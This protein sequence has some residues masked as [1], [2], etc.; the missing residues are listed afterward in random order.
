MTIL[1]T[2]DV[3][4]EISV[5]VS[6]APKVLVGITDPSA[7]TTLVSVPPPP[8]FRVLTADE[9]TLLA[10][11]G[12]AGPPGPQG[13]PGPP[14]PPGPEGPEG[15]EGD[16]GATGATGPP[17]STGAAG[18]QGP[19]GPQGIPG[20]TGPTGATGPKGD[21]GDKGDIGADSTVPG[22]PGATGPAGS[23]GP[24]GPAGADSTVPGPTGPTG[25]QGVK[26]D[27]GDQGPTGATGTAGAPGATGPAGAT[28]ATGATGPGV[29]P[30][31]TLDQV[32]AKASAVDYAT[33]WVTPAVGVGTDNVIGSLDV[34]F[35]ADASANTTL[36]AMAA[37][38]DYLATSV[39][40]VT[41]VD[42]TAVG[43]VRFVVKRMATA[44]AA[45]AV[46]NL[47][48]SLTD[49]ASVFSAAAWTAIPAQVSLVTPNITLDTGWINLPV[50]MKVNNVY[51]A[52]T[53]AGGDGSAAPVVGSIRAFFKG[54]GPLGPEGPQGPA[55]A[56]GVPG[57]D[58]RIKVRR[59]SAFS[60]TST[61]TDVI[62]NTEIYDTNNAYN[63]ATGVFTAPQA[64]TYKITTQILGVASAVGVWF[65]THCLLNGSTIANGSCPPAT[66][67]NQV[68]T[69]QITTTVA[70]AAN[71]T[72]KIA[73]QSMGTGF[74]DQGQANSDQTFLTIELITTGAQGPVGA[75]GAQG[76]QGDPGPTGPQG[77]QGATGAQGPPGPL[78]QATADSLYVNVAGD[79]MTGPLVVG[80]NVTVNGVMGKPA[81]DLVISG[82]AGGKVDFQLT[83]ITGVPT[84]TGSTEAVP[85]G[86]VDS[87]VNNL[88]AN[89]VA[90]AGD[91]MT[92]DLN[93]AS[94]AQ[95][96]V[97]G[98]WGPTGG[99]LYLG[100]QGA[101]RV[102]FNGS[103]IFG[104]PD[105]GTGSQEAVNR[106]FVDNIGGPYRRFA[107]VTSM[108][109]WP[110]PVGGALAYITADGSWHV[111]KPPTWYVLMRPWTAFTP[112][113]ICPGGTNPTLG[114]GSTQM[115]R[116]NLVNNLCSFSL[117][118]AFGTGGGFAAGNGQY[119]V[120]GFPIAM[121]VNFGN[122]LPAGSGHLTL[123]AGNGFRYN[124]QALR[125]PGQNGFEI[126]TP[127]PWWS[128]S[129]QVPV[130]GNAIQ[131]WG[132]YEVDN[133]PS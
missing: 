75:T 28:G 68:Q 101:G 78:D 41:K 95:I 88:T 39:R 133:V 109:A 71:D 77:P 1:I 79:T 108:K 32:L 35:V 94:G 12:T 116:Y 64:G 60:I 69:A 23:T 73:T 57:P 86:Y 31:G 20:S 125:S 7:L 15:P 112:T 38:E 102:D 26:G 103:P 114:T 44:A 47:K 49:P 70:L 10:S 45:G 131:L 90:K 52:V 43:Q 111:Y 8:E 3:T 119:V 100:K 91:T 33:K 17:G 63:P 53:Q 98:V 96:F 85:K 19:Q 126:Y 48:Y 83:P 115:G 51:L 2:T 27:Q 67:V 46:L 97:G 124:P 76:P 110:S 84:P 122:Y 40:H 132:A 16:V 65:Y 82:I 118:I 37:A 66:A 127:A 87:Y 99:V 123:T 6:D 18:V 130:A 121:S 113:L 128:N 104:V 11:V 59:T 89:K 80:G 5:T 30:G 54:T 92:G 34:T 81:T 24:A 105:P 93:F 56:P 4:P 36:T 9:I 29:A 50:G 55:G 14:G 129:P 106:N 21:K 61:F 62:F 107:N 72:I 74:L 58:L 120:A 22:P 42:L 117:N 13:D 25:P